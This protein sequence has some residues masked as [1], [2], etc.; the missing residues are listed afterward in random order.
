MVLDT[1]GTKDVNPYFNS[2]YINPQTVEIKFHG[3]GIQSVLNFLQDVH[4][5]KYQNVN[6]KKLTSIRPSFQ[7]GLISS[8]VIDAAH[9]SLIDH[10]SSHVEIQL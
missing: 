2:S 7:A 10:K 1:Q 3:Y 4:L 6:L 9:Q 5:V 8:A